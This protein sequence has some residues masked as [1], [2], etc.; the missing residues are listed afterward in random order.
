MFGT[1]VY[2]AEIYYGKYDCDDFL[3][4]FSTT[5]KAQAACRADAN[6]DALVWQGHGDV[7]RAENTKYNFEYV[8]RAVA[9]DH[10]VT[11]NG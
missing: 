1:H 2:I 11:R 6:S 7:I 4:V 5:E 10:V 8:I 9:L 3:G